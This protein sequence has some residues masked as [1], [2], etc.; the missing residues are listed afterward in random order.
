MKQTLSWAERFALIDH[1]NPTDTQACAVFKL[2]P[3]ELSTAKQL[4]QQGVFASS[5]TLDV[6]KYASLFPSSVVSTATATVHD[7]PE[8]ASRPARQ[9]QK[10]GR[11]GDKIVR[12]FQAVP[13]TPVEVDQFIAQHGVSLAVLR[14]SKRFIEAMD[15]NVATQI[16]C[17]HVKQDKKTKRLVIWRE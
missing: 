13:S 9:P 15:S 10:R 5:R 17:I 16:G 12:A 6:T 1:Y 11:K 8:S 14:Q 7:R 4:R 3:D 2:T